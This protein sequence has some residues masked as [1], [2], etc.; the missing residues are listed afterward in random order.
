MFDLKKLFARELRARKADALDPDSDYRPSDPRG[1]GLEVEYHGLIAGQFQRWGLAPG[2]VRIEVRL[3]GKAPDGFDVFVGM[4]RLANWERTTALRVLLGLPLLEAKVRKSVRATWLAD[5]S[6]FGGLWLHASEQLSG[7]PAAAELR[8]LM[9]QLAPPT[10]AAAGA[11]A[12]QHAGA[13]PSSSLPP[14]QT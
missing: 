14:S 8:Y 13:F 6:H 9:L 1:E 5:F 12:S 10:P 7:G 4:V 11:G 2:C 3:V